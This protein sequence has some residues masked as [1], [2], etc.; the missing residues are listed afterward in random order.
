MSTTTTI[1]PATTMPPT[2]TSVV[3][4]ATTADPN[5]LAQ[6]LQAVLDRYESLVMRSRSNPELPFTDEELL[7][8]LQTVATTDFLG[9]FWVPKWQQDREDG[10]AVRE[11]AKGHRGLLLTSVVPSAA[12][13]TGTYCFF[14]DSVTY[15]VADGDTVNDD[16]SVSH[17]T[18]RLVYSGDLW[19]IDDVRRSTSASASSTRN[20]CPSEALAP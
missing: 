17:G 2:T 20:P 7:S 5:V 19:K 18:I 8:E 3:A 15:R 13:V 10:T 12:V 14:D 6:Q 9:L 1:A 11:S 4:D 16:V